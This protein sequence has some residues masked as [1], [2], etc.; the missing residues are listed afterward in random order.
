MEHIL[1]QPMRFLHCTR[2]TSMADTLATLDTDI[3]VVIVSC[4]TDVITALGTAQDPVDAIER[5]MNA[6][7]SALYSLYD[8]RGSTL[9]VFIGPCT[10]RNTPNFGSLSK[11]GMV[12]K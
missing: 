7:D 4:M 2:F 11:L 10:P 9:K 3:R 1:G 8:Q 12:S 6:I 5:G